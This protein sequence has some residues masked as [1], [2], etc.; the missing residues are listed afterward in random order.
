MH[1]LK[2]HVRG[3]RIVMDE[4]TDLPD[5]EVRVA[6]IDGDDLD[7]TERAELHAALAEA[8][9]EFGAGQGVSEEKFWASFRAAE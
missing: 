9:A 6:V 8:E 5:G 7:D 4:P 3:G 1:A 2:A